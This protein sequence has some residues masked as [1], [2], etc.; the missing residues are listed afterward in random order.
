MEIKAADIL[1]K[2]FCIN[3]NRNN[4]TERKQNELRVLIYNVGVYWLP[5]A[6]QQRAR[7]MHQLQKQ[8]R[9]N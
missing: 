6:L 7:Q 2:K 1:D 8:V 4:N 5:F 3:N 9:A